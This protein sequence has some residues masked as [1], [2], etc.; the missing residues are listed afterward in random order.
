MGAEL[1]NYKMRL[2]DMENKSKRE[3]YQRQQ[4]ANSRIVKTNFRPLRFVGEP[5]TF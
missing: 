3:F 4:I 5:K 2:L 1:D